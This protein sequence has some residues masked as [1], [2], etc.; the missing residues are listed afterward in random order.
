MTFALDHGGRTLVVIG[1]LLFLAGLLQG[2]AV[3]QFTNPRMALSAHLDAVQSGIALMIA[4]A[5][6]SCAR[7]SMLAEKIARWTLA[8][9]MV[10]LWMGI[11][12]AAVTGA[13]DALPMA[14]KGYSAGPVEELITTGIIA[15]SSFALLVGWVLF[16]IGLIRKA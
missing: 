4:G 2:L 12:L 15:G 8:A 14:A 5:L 9:G 1:A 3:D 11:T 16:A 6:W 10:G 13:A 7:W